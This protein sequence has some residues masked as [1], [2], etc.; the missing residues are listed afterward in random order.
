V[1]E[2]KPRAV[3]SVGY[4]DRPKRA[5]WDND[6]RFAI[7][8]LYYGFVRNVVLRLPPL[9]SLLIRMSLLNP[10]ITARR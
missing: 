5:P 9:V 8:L 4:R 6:L 10:V 7:K 2:L 3:P 1:P